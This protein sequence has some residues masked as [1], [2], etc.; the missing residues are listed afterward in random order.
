MN[1]QLLRNLFVFATAAFLLCACYPS[2]NPFFTEK[3]VVFEPGLVGE[4]QTKDTNE[5]LRTWKFVAATNNAYELTVIDKND[6]HGQFEAHLVKLKNEQ[7]LDIEPSDCNYATNQNDLVA[8]CM[9]PGHLLFRVPQTEPNLKLAFCNFDW[10]KKFL[11]AHPAALAHRT[12]HD[13]ILL[14]APTAELQKFVMEHLGTNELFQ[15]PG[16]LI[17]V[18]NTQPQSPIQ[19]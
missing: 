13:T 6:K 12:E 7:F 14:T 8:S 1:T 17:R 9:F 16:E 5:D 2:V 4:W 18:T 15:E 3:D 19:K 11:E 10:L